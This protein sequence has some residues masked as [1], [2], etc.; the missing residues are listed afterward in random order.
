MVKRSRQPMPP[1]RNTA[2]KFMENLDCWWSINLGKWEMLGRDCCWTAISP[3]SL[4]Q[5]H[6]ADCTAGDR[7]HHVAL[8]SVKDSSNCDT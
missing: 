1:P 5:Q 3:N 7:Y 4:N 8:P 2:M 6:V